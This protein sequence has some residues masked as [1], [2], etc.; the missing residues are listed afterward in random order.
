MR[1]QPFLAYLTFLWCVQAEP[2]LLDAIPLRPE[3]GKLLEVTL[4]LNDLPGDG[5]VNG[6]PMPGDVLQDPFVGRGGAPFIVFGLKSV[7]GNGNAKV[8]QIAPRIGNGPD[9][10]GD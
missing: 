9:G 5:A 10:A 2:N 6:D 8:G 1:G 4:A 3:S 7:D